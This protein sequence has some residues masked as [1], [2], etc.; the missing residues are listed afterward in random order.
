VTAAA[1]ISSEQTRE[2]IF[3]HGGNDRKGGLAEPFD[4]EDRESEEAEY[5][6]SD[7][8]SFLHDRLKVHL[9][10]EGIRHDVIDACLTGDRT[11]DLTDLV[12][13]TRAL[14]A[15]LKTEDGD[16]LIQGYRRAKNI[17]DQAQAADG[18][19]YSYGADPKL[20]REAE[21]TALFGALTDAR[22]RID[23]ALKAEDYAAAMRALAALRAPIDAFFGAVQVNTE[24]QVLR[25][26]RLNLL[27]E[28]VRTCER[29]AALDRVAA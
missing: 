9:R 1:S 25:R 17:L 11:D 15:F 5:E 13:R 12:A 22:P 24:E 23:A 21:E 19:E 7:L 10:D 20:A 14:D 3:Q 26:N 16:N 29:I 6:A 28:I 2:D 27:S 4:T 18:V 8:L